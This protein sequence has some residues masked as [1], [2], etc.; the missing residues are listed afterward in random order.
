M[1]EVSV[2][3]PVFNGAVTVASAIDSALAQRFDGSVEI[4]AIN[5]G[6]SDGTREVL[7]GYGDRIRVINQPNT[8]VSAASNRGVRESNGEFVAFLD[9]DDSW[10]PEKLARTVPILRANPDIALVYHDGLEVDSAGRVVKT[11][12]YPGGPIAP[13]SLEDLLCFD[14][15][16]Q[17]ILKDSVVMRREIFER[18]GGFCES[19]PCGEDKFLWLVARELGSFEFVSEPLLR[20]GY[21]PSSRREE[22]YVRG[23]TILDRL[24][25]ERYPS[26]NH[27]DVLLHTLM[28]AGSEAMRRGDRSAA[29][30]RYAAALRRNP[31]RA[32]T[33]G[34]VACALMPGRVGSAVAKMV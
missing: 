26:K 32:R 16:R 8:G 30:R 33:Y 15:P 19:L 10:M 27:A 7:R 2:V 22:W 11:S 3:I 13:P 34:A 17:F 9:A 18:C 1:A 4:V 20:R 12:Y 24:V 31:L 25:R 14:S 6:S 5:D 23:A 28:W 29:I 21:E